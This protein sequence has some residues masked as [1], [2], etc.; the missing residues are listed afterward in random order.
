MVVP[1][2]RRRLGLLA[3]LLLLL[4]PG[5]G[6]AASPVT[7]LTPA[8]AQALITARGGQADFVI[9]DVRTPEEFRQGR[10]A[11]AVNLNLAAPDFPARLAKLDRTKTYLVYCRSGNRSARAI[12]AMRQLDFGSL[13][14][15]Y[16]GVLGWQQQRLPLPR[17]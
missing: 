1:M 9:L 6:L 13:Y 4:A 15:L 14:H 8:E 16:Q 12:D 3:A 7:D 10:L 5:S 11:G 2:T 17:P